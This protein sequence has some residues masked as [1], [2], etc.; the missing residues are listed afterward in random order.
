RAAHGPEPLLRLRPEPQRALCDLVEDV[1][2]H[3]A[4]RIGLLGVQEHGTLRAALD[5]YARLE[6]FDRRCSAMRKLDPHGA[7]VS[8]DLDHP[9]ECTTEFSAGSLARR[10]WAD[11]CQ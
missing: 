10:P 11:R 7:I 5:G 6:P 8:V 2:D 1:V 9:E 3:L 4:Q